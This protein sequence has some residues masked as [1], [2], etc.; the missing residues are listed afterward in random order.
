MNQKPNSSKNDVKLVDV[1]SY[2]TVC[3]LLFREWFRP[4][5]LQPLDCVVVTSSTDTSHCGL[6]LDTAWPWW[7]K[8][9][10]WI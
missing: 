8:T 7:C 1:R 5:L 6:W 10:G 3:S 9:Q 4:D 2:P